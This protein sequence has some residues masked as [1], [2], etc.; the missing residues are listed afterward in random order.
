M[1]RF[2]HRPSSRRTSGRRPRS[3]ILL[4]DT[5][6][7]IRR[8]SRPDGPGLAARTGCWVGTM[9]LT[10][11]GLDS[12][13]GRE[14]R[15]HG[16]ARPPHWVVAT[17][18]AL[19]ACLAACTHVSPLPPTPVPASPRIVAGLYLSALLGGSRDQALTLIKPDAWCTPP[20][21]DDVFESQITTL[22]RTHIRDLSVQDE[23]V[24]GWV[25]YPPGTEAAS[26]KFEFS[27]DE[28]EWRSAGV[29]VAI[30]QGR[31]CDTRLSIN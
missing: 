5:P 18:L 9:S 29:F 31:I 22:S 3:F 6:A 28:V 30:V 24:A 7:H 4:K 10:G 11:L 17:Q 14:R 27:P 1:P 15:A 2:T 8:P 25:A 23:D 16:G 26:I 21:F 19:T 13:D 12:V 20:D